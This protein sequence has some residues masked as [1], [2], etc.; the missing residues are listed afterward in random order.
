MSLECP[1]IKPKIFSDSILYVLQ[2][3][4]LEIFVS[5]RDLHRWAQFGFLKPGRHPLEGNGSLEINTHHKYCPVISLEL[6]AFHPSLCPP[7]IL[8]PPCFKCANQSTYWNMV[9]DPWACCH[10]PWI[11]LKWY[12]LSAVS[13]NQSSEHM[14]FYYIWGTCW[15]TR[16][17]QHLFLK[18][19]HP[20]SSFSK[21]VT[22]C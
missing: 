1:F 2:F 11:K 9:F 15:Q 8:P 18:S 3:E 7:F 13:W 21:W 12:T 6:E 16:R 10:F 4:G 20:I 5:P 17:Y 19:V 22:V 14:W